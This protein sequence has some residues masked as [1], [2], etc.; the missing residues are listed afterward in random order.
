MRLQ[1]KN[2]LLHKF[3][4]VQPPYFYTPWRNSTKRKSRLK[5]S[6]STDGS[7]NKSG[8]V[9][10]TVGPATEKARRCQ[11]CCDETVECPRKD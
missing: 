10:Q 7:C 5:F 8:N 9:F 3:G 1:V 11:M 2:A 6:D 4:F